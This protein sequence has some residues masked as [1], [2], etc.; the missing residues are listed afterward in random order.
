MS[1]NVILVLNTDYSNYM[2]YWKLVDTNTHISLNFSLLN[3]VLLLFLQFTLWSC[4]IQRKA[5]GQQET[6]LF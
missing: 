1:L 3:T 5:V 6:D 4:D 2:F